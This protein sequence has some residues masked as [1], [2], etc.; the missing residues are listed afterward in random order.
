MSDIRH[1][2]VDVR[3]CQAIESGEMPKELLVVGPAGT[4]KT[5]A[6]L[7]VIHTIARDNPGLRILFLRATRSSL[8][9]SVL[10]TYEQEILPADECRG[11]AAGAGRPSR[12]SY[13]YPNGT[14]I[15]V[16][17]LDRNPTRILSTAWDIVFANECVELQEGVWETICSR[18]GRPGRDRR[19][20]WMLGDTNPSYP[21][22]WLKK[23]ADSGG[24][25]LWD[26]THEANPVMHD[27]RAWTDAGRQYLA[28]L[29]K[30]TGPRRKRLRDGIWAQGEGIWFDSFDGLEGGPH[31]T[32]D[33]D[34]IPGLPT[35]CA[36]DSGVWTG[37]VWFQVSERASARYGEQPTVRVNVFDDYLTENVTAERNAR[38]IREK[39]RAGNYHVRK[40]FTDPAGG[41]RN[42][43][44]P[45]VIAEYERAG[46]APLDRWPMRS[47]ADGLE[48]IQ[49]L[50]GGEGNPPSL[51]IHPRCKHTKDAF[52]GYRRAKRANQ[53]MD[54]PEDPQHP[55]EEMID[56]LRGGLV[57][58]FPEG[59]APKPR[60]RSVPASRLC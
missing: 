43:V 48:L 53:L 16:A 7:S 44:G 35:Y 29:D 37:A 33:A 46:L 54:W 6:I 25:A 59:R 11:I 2:R 57:A 50:L 14:D 55:S 10:V 9:E 60:L 49:S 58:V 52:A 40:Y 38:A 4:G 3:L 41:S 24:I 42:P 28:S 23:K 56:S 13:R 1:R 34:Y 45:T 21:E 30:L 12:H 22:H 47:V 17:G 27:G 18:M 8:T 36:I 31:V 32:A 51:R 5:Y 15:V 20:G 26:T 19:F 39:S